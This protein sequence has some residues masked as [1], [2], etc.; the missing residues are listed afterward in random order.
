VTWPEN[1]DFDED[2]LPG[3]LLGRF[4]D[5]VDEAVGDVGHPLGALR[6][7]LRGGEHLRALFHVGQAVIEKGEDVGS[8]LLAE[9]VARAQILIDPDL[10]GRGLS[11]CRFSGPF[12]DAGALT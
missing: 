6:V 4:D 12:G 1:G 8:D 5:G 10:H 2:A 3:A 7:A 9:T 11:G